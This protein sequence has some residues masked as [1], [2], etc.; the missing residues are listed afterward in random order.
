MDKSLIK[1]V[2]EKTDWKDAIKSGVSL[3]V[4]KKYCTNEL[5]DKIIESVNTNG[6][7]FIIM[8]H[9]ALAHA[10]P[11]PWINE[12]GLSLIKFDNEVKFSNEERHNVS[13]LFTLSATD[14]ESH[15]GIL[16]KFSELFMN[17]HDLVNK[18]SS[19]TTVEEIQSI[20]KDL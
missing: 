18:L 3:L 20:L 17:D 2:K 15:M 9:V 4:N 16:M 5:A 19:A 7:Y 12:I 13:L 11:G 8:P 1:I 6:P 14:G 10:A